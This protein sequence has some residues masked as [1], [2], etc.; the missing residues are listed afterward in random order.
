MNRHQEQHAKD[1]TSYA[2]FLKKNGTEPEFSG[3]TEQQ[4]E[5]FNKLHRKWINKWDK[6]SKT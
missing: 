6:W 2:K 3:T 4:K 5:K 1:Q